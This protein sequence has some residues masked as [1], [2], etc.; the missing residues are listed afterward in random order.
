MF[1][2]CQSVRVSESDGE[3]QGVEVALEKRID[4]ISLNQGGNNSPAG[5]VLN[6]ASGQSVSLNEVQKIK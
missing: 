3:Q 1:L 2:R 5:T 6:L 4:S